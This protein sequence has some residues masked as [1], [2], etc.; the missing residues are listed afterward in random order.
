MGD[1]SKC[2]VAHGANKIAASGSRANQKWW[3]EQL[4]LKVLNQNS[5]NVNPVSYT[6]LT[7]PTTP[8][9]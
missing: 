4:N 5:A 9:V 7:L 1:I 6:H 8:Y 3:P 2:P